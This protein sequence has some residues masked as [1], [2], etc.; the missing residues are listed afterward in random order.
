[1]KTRL[2][3]NVLL[4]AI[5]LINGY[6]I[7]LP[8]A[9]SILFWLD[10]QDGSEVARL[11]K[12]IAPTPADTKASVPADDRLIV[13]GMMLDEPIHMGPTA[14]TLRQGLWLR[15]QGST[16]D[17]GSNTVIVGHR[18]TYTNPRGQFYHLDKVKMGDTIGVAWKGVMYTY[19]VHTIKVVSADTIAVEAPTDKPTLTLYTCTPLWLPTERLVI[20]AE[21]EAS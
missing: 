4:I 15:P 16:P 18:F 7:L 14:R 13:P 6:I 20:V 1:M 3:H 12:R 19:T 10:K 2:V 5:V 11:E 8:V 21:G 17:K 9:P